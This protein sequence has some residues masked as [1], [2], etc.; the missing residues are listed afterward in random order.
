MLASAN[1]VFSARPDD[2]R[3]LPRTL[4]GRGDT[5]EA[6]MYA[7]V[8]FEQRPDAEGFGTLMEV[9][10]VTHSVEQA[11]ER[12]FTPTS[13]EPAGRIHFTLAARQAQPARAVRQQVWAQRVALSEAAGGMVSATCIVAREVDPPAGVKPIEWRLL[14]NREVNDL[15]APARMNSERQQLTKRDKEED[16]P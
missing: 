1:N 9:A 12:A 2:I 3:F 15:D 11:R 13:G 7:W 10:R 16:S 6:N 14:S 4:L 8:C 5:V